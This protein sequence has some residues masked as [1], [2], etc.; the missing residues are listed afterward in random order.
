MSLPL[1]VYILT[2][3]QNGIRP[4]KLAMMEVWGNAGTQEL[5]ETG[6]S[7]ENPL[8]SSIVRYTVPTCEGPW[9][10][11][12]G[13]PPPGIEPDSPR[14]EA[15]GLTTT[16]PRP[17]LRLIFLRLVQV[18]L[19]TQPS[20]AS[21]SRPSVSKPSVDLFVR[22]LKAT[23]NSPSAVDPS[24]QK[25][26]S[27]TT[28]QHELSRPETNVS[29][30]RYSSGANRDF[31]SRKVN[32]GWVKG[33]GLARSN[34]QY[35]GR[36]PRCLSGWPAN[37]PPMRTGFSP[38]PG[39]SRIFASENRA[40]RC[41]WQAG[42]IG[43]LPF[44]LLSGVAPFSPHFILIGSRDLVVESRPSLSTQFNIRIQAPSPDTHS[45]ITPGDVNKPFPIQS[46]WTMPLV[47]GFSRGSHVS[48]A[49]VFR[50]CSML[51]SLHTHRLSRP[52]YSSATREKTLLGNLQYAKMLCSILAVLQVA[53]IPE[54]RFPKRVS[55][56]S[57]II[58]SSRGFRKD[59]VTV[60]GLYPHHRDETAR[61]FLRR[62]HNRSLIGRTRL[63]GTD[64]VS[65]RLLHVAD[66]SPPL[67]RLLSIGPEE[68]LTSVT[69]Q[70]RVNK[71]TE[72]VRVNRQG[73]H[74]HHAPYQTGSAMIAAYSETSCIPVTTNPAFRQGSGEI[75]ARLES[76]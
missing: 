14:C 51:T 73:K 18:K 40:G 43:D 11:G 20:V 36:G 37:L 23:H 60:N 55:F 30:C 38:R 45:G 62:W 3:T 35:T 16:P 52:P 17:Q 22:Q 58:G 13:T 46:Y 64:L 70:R 69:R 26:I 61:R 75:R 6:D 71:Q 68:Q 7:R 19:G 39:H 53:N 72:P 32:S 47:S 74:K 66:S 15:N 10:G 33:Y 28:Q 67:P 2:D 42:F 24:G 25:I 31:D 8:I 59:E 54:I 57:S 63:W 12:G 44:P 4:L 48:P 65:D 27:V 50:R 9:R 29:N 49:L 1:H 76:R 34:P 41:R 21:V 56:P 5:G